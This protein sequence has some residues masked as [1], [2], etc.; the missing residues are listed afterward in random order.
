MPSSADKSGTSARTFWCSFLT[1]RYRPG[2][3]L[4]NI[5]ASTVRLTWLRSDMAAVSSWTLTSG[6]L[7][8]W[9][10]SSFT[11]VGST[12]TLGM[13]QVSLPHGS[14]RLGDQA[15]AFLMSSTATM[16]PVPI[17]IDLSTQALA[18]FAGGGRALTTP[19][20]VT[21]GV[22]SVSSATIPFGVSSI[23]R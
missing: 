17:I 8:T 19:V 9:S 4:A 2:S 11:Q 18:E 23:S 6:T 3:G 16:A 7:G 1:L 14:L 13:Y 12:S 22:V 5:V 21:T 10:T 15:I 20:G